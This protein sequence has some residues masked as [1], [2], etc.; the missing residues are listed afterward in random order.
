MLFNLINKAIVDNTSLSFAIGVVYVRETV[1]LSSYV[2]CTPDL[3]AYDYKKC[4]HAEISSLPVIGKQSGIKVCKPLRRRKQES[5]VPSQVCQNWADFVAPQPLEGRTPGGRCCVWRNGL[6][7]P[8]LSCAAAAR[9][10]YAAA[11]R[12][13]GTAAAT[14]MLPLLVV[15]ATT[16]AR[17]APQ[18]LQLPLAVVAC[19]CWLVS[20]VVV[21]AAGRSCYKQPIIERNPSV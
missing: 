5:R 3:T 7:L 6:L 21:A 18:L 1:V 13:P 9:L 20:P 12:L 19:G 17:T 11:A 10:F 16:A 14:V 15:A 4:L 8:G 2:N